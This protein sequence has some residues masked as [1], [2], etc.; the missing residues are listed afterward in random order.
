M[1]AT[2][3]TPELKEVC[4]SREL[5]VQFHAYVPTGDSSFTTDLRIALSEDAP[6][7]FRFEPFEDFLG[8][9]SRLHSKDKAEERFARVLNYIYSFQKEKWFD[10]V[11]REKLMK[12]SVDEA[13]HQS[14]DQLWLKTRFIDKE[15]SRQASFHARYKLRAAIRSGADL[16]D[17]NPSEETVYQLSRI[18][19]AR[20]CADHLL[21]GFCAL[22][23]FPSA[24]ERSEHKDFTL[25]ESDQRK[26]RDW[27]GWGTRR[28]KPCFRNRLLH[29][30]LIPYDDIQPLFESLSYDEA[31]ECAQEELDKDKNQIEAILAYQPLLESVSQE[32]GS[33]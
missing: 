15:S 30:D 18:E 22:T 2:R 6:P 21:K 33:A 10:D 27:F 12:D 24:N 14:I 26:I 28:L 19:H 23:D 1:V 31:E 25:D 7:C 32:H 3:L 20:W 9:Y 4:A 16:E 17:K 29:V 8:E 11:L 13:L 5:P